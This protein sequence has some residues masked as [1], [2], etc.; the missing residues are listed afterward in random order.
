[1]EQAAAQ[2]RLRPGDRI[3]IQANNRTFEILRARHQ[4]AHPER[5]FQAPRLDDSG[6]LSMTLAEAF[7]AFGAHFSWGDD[8]PFVS[9]Q[10]EYPA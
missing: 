9:L 10:G 4:K 2:M 3:K 6:C 7:G 8:A 5:P 1:M